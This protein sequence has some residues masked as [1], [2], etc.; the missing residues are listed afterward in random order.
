[1]TGLDWAGGTWHAH[2]PNNSERL[3]SGGAMFQEIHNSV[4]QELQEGLLLLRTQDSF[5]IFAKVQTCT[6]NNKQLLS[7]FIC[8]ALCLGA[9]IKYYL[10][11]NPAN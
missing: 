8:H 3:T 10:I 9:F 5:L 2:V 1:M 6:Q 7:I 11:F 4:G